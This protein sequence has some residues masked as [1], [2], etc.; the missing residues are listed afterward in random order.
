MY[1]ATLEC[2]RVRES[3][4]ERGGIDFCKRLAV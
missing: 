3:V 1:S 2:V 4:C